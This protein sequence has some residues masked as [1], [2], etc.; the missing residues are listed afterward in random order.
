MIRFKLSCLMLVM[1]LITSCIKEKEEVPQFEVTAQN[2]SV[3][4]GE[5]VTFNISGDAKVISFY[6]GEFKNDYAFKDGRILTLDAAK[7]LFTTRV[8]FGTQP[9]Q[10]KVLTSTDFNGDYTIPSLRA[11]KWNDITNRFTYATTTTNVTSPEKDITDQITEG[12]PL[13]I[14]FKYV[15]L[16]QTA[17]GTVRSW[18]VSG[19]TLNTQT[20]LGLAT[21]MDQKTA[22]WSLIQSDNIADPSRS[23][24]SSAGTLTLRGNV[25]A[26]PE[27]ETEIW[28]VS[29]ALNLGKVDL[30]PDFAVPIKNV[31]DNRLES[32]TYTFN[33]PG[34]Y[35]VVFVGANTSIYG[36]ESVVKEIAVTVNP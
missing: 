32:Y 4:A 29:K 30:G 14:A 5:K 20:A 22:A 7:L 21:A 17:N 23:T 11:A 26:T 27:V 19:L 24:V 18:T 2:T 25:S 8:Q 6:S 34:A 12:K 28:A 3:K 33:T 16:P 31:L 1:A 10:L 35:K 13:Y 36:Q 9:N 15:T